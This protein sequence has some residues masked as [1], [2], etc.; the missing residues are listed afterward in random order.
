MSIQIIKPFDSHLHLRMGKMAELVSPMSSRQF[1]D[2]IVMPNLQPPIVAVEQAIS[3]RNY[4]MEIA[5]C[6]YY[7]ALYLT[8]STTIEEVEKVADNPFIIGF[9]LYP[10]NATTGSQEG[11]SDVKNLYHLFEKMEKLRIPLMIHSEVTR[12]D[13]DIFDREN[14][15]IEEILIDVVEK[16]PRLMITLEHITTSDAVEFVLNTSNV[17]ASITAHHLLINRN[18]IFTV[19]EKTALNPHNFCL[20]VAKAEEHRKAL[21]KAATSGNRKFF[22]GTDSA[23]HPLNYKESSCGCAGCFTGLHAIELYA[24]AFEQ[25]NSLDKLENFLS[26]HGRIH[27][28]IDIPDKYLNIYEA[29][30]LIPDYIGDEKLTPFMAGQI[31]N[32]KVQ[33][34]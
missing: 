19:D 20:P 18:A 8:E 34:E 32:W 24:T 17:V 12:S 23:P 7:M 30:Y 5:K 11:I 13:V 1:S 15:F 2:V 6:N 10:L 33:E 29:N 14:V 22:A 16:F 21:L 4:L 26:I 3:Y 27:Y 28:G 9:K 25:T 31:L